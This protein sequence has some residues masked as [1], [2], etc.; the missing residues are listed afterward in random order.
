ML[1]DVR[2]GYI[3]PE[4]AKKDYGVVIVEQA[5][6]YIIDRERTTELRTGKEGR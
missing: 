6:D 2:M 4:S 3:K 5:G 1:I